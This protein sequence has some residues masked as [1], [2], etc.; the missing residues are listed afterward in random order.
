[1]RI[2]EKKCPNCGASLEFDDKAKSCKCEYCKRSFEIERENYVNGEYNYNLT[3]KKFS[4]IF[5]IVFFIVFAF[6]AFCGFTIFKSIHFS[7]FDK[8]KKLY[9][10]VNEIDS[11]ALTVLDGKAYWDIEKADVEIDEYG[12]EAP[13]KRNKIYVAYNKKEKKNSIIVVY[14][15]TYKLTFDRDRVTIL[16]PI[17]YNNIKNDNMGTDIAF[18]N[19]Y[20]KGPEYYLNLEHSEYAR[21]YQD[22]ESLEKEV[23]NPLKNQGYKVTKK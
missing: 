16:V 23:I 14:K 4:N 21:G 18:E 8:D 3:Q 17:I 20:V 22:I 2:I 15:A 9:T 10:N 6:I 5:L 11:Q 19:G 7:S 1:M 12:L 13:V